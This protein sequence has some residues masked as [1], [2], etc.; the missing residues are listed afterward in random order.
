M[1]L[2]DINKTALLISALRI[3]SIISIPFCLLWVCFNPGDWPWLV[4]GIL[5]VRIYV[6]PLVRSMMLHRY[7]SHHSFKVKPWLHKFFCIS[8][9]FAGVSPVTAAAVHRFHHRHSDTLKDPHS[10]LNGILSSL[11]YNRKLV[12][13]FNYSGFMD[14]STVPFDLLRDKSA[15]F[16]HKNLAVLCLVTMLA[17]AAVSWKLLVFGY[18]F[19]VGLALAETGILGLVH[20]HKKIW[21]S[22]RNFDTDDCS[23]NTKWINWWYAE[24][25]HNNHHA[26]PTAWN[27]GMKPGEIDYVAYAIKYIFAERDSLREHE[28]STKI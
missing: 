9:I 3:S 14:K 8:A 11:S 7:F 10:P 18:V 13:G 5:W 24:G 1:K 16:V 15:M 23:L 17:C 2:S 27:Q 6:Q 25:F 28:H 19:G 21:G 22:Y 20:G 4:G 26:Y 12:L